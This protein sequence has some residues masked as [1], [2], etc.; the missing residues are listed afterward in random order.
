MIKSLSKNSSKLT[1][2]N[3][4][5]FTDN[6]CNRLDLIRTAILSSGIEP[7]NIDDLLSRISISHDQPI[8]FSTKGKP[9]HKNG[10]LV[11]Y[12]DQG[13]PFVVIAGDWA[14]GI[15]MKW[16]ASRLSEQSAEEQQA[17]NRKIRLAKAFREQEQSRK[18]ETAAVK[19]QDYWK[20]SAPANANHP[21]LIQKNIQPL[22]LRQISDYLIV[23]M[24]D[25]DGKLWNLQRIYPDGTKKF[26]AGGK[27]KGCFALLGELSNGPIYICEGFA[28][29]ATIHN[30]S[31]LPTV[32][33]MNA[34]NLTAVCIAVA[35][36]SPQVTVCADNDHKTAGNPGIS[37]GR[38]AA[39]TVNAALTWPEPCGP[40]C[41]CTD[42][43]DLSNCKHAVRV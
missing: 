5:H 26:M 42:F 27:V 29:G 35:S 15:E 32:C 8:R 3:I 6:Y 17:I 16:V 37:L 23:P 10:W 7:I 41:N 9:N 21:Y 43:N 39:K 31:G 2:H 36:L 14:S 25:I 19:A 18:W 20:T 34:N 13:L 28:T 33:A 40:E 30:A 11:S 38:E 4:H 12:S 22:T 24:V 1:S